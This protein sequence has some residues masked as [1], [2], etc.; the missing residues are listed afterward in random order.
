MIHAG[1]PWRPDF[2]FL[3]NALF[4]SVQLLDKMVSNCCK[5]A[6]LTREGDLP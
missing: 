4:V 2:L 6:H 5:R 1:P 3:T